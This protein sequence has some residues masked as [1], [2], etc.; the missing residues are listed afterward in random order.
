ME[1]KGL[2]FRKALFFQRFVKLARKG[3]DRIDLSSN[4]TAPCC[5]SKFSCFG[6]LLSEAE[7][8]PFVL[9]ALGLEALGLEPGSEPAL[10][11]FQPVW[12]FLFSFP[13][14]MRIRF[15]PRRILVLQPGNKYRPCSILR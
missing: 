15:P 10:S 6:C 5:Y 2:N 12:S 4:A 9:E 11:V 3:A 8:E 13:S 1:C 7:L 14:W